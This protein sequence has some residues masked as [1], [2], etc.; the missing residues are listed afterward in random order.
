MKPFLI[1][2]IG[3]TLLSDDGIGPHLV[4]ALQD[5]LPSDMFDFRREYV[6]HLEILDILKSYQ[7][8]II[9]DGARSEEQ[10]PGRISFYEPG[11]YHNTVHLDNYH[12]ISFREMVD[13]ADILEMDIPKVIRIISIEI[14]E[15]KVFSEQLSPPLQAVFDTLVECCYIFINQTIETLKQ[16]TTSQ[17]G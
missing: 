1:I 14:Q 11:N 7:A 17:Q 6:C 8:A 3:N 10:I 12:D 13:M 2:G 15:D 16:Y 5:L 4:D 9:I